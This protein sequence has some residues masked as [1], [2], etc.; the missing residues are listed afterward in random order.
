[1]KY[2][3]TKTRRSTRQRGAVIVETALT[4][5]PLFSFIFATLDISMAVTMQNTLQFAAR[6]G[7]RYAVTSQTLTAGTGHDA[8]IKS[9]VVAN[10]MGMMPFL[11]PSGGNSDPDSYI[12]ITYYNPSTLAL[13][14]GANSNR[15]GNI[16]K[17]TISG[18]RYSW[19]GPLTR[20]S[21]ALNLSSSSSDVMEASPNGQPPAR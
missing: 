3:K 15:G 5:I 9:V 12:T 16:C 13:V 17:V 4:I 19:M 7:V 10:T 14:T 21:A 18:L 1:M 2:F 11:I 20:D 8:S 6:Q